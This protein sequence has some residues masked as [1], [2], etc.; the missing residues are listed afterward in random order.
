MG[1]I[2]VRYVGEIGIKG[3]NRFYFVKRLRHNLRDALK[4]SAAYGRVWSE[5]QRIYAEVQDDA[6]GAASAEG[7]S[8]RALA[9]LRRVFGVASLSPVHQVPSEMEAIQEA[10]VTVAERAALQS[11]MTFRVRA[12]RADKAFP[13]TSPEIGRI[14]GGAVWQK[15]QANVDLSDAAHV[16]IGVEVRPEGT[17]VFGETIPGPGGMP[18]GTQGRVFSLL[19]GG[20]DSPVATWLMMR[21]GCGVI[22]LHF[23]Q[24]Q[25]Q[26]QK[27]LEL[28]RILDEWSFG[29]TIK[30]I[31]VDHHQLLDPIADRLQQIGEERWTCLFCKRAMIAKAAELAPRYRVQ[32][33][34]MGDSL[35]Q[36]ASQTMDNMIAISWRAPLPI[37]R[38]LVACDKNQIMD[39]ARRIGTYDVSSRTAAPCPFLPDHP[40]TSARL[41]HLHDIMAQLA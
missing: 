40:I 5:G 39:L 23:A 15:T 2:L 38:P 14:V 24:S 7:V 6:Q 33:V 41:E 35:G 16:T 12:Q 21:R 17:L 11:P 32:A 4:R 37:F 26:E 27:A 1:L 29:W 10:A 8:P 9:A 25:V 13:Y 31:V 20:I 34:V 28:C 30:P 3:K 18:L 19:S 22:P 36:V